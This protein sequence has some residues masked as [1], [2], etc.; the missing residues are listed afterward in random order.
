MPLTITAANVKLKGNTKPPVLVQ[1]GETVTQGQPLYP[2]ASDSNKFW[3]ADADTA[4][5]AAA[6]GIAMTPGVAGDYVLLAKEGCP[7]SLGAT[8]VVGQV[9]C[10]SATAGGIDAFS[11]VASGDYVTIIGV[12]SAADSITLIMEATGVAKA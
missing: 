3:K 1:V 12:A 8:L 7:I 2:K 4:A 11:D 9:Y 6:Q 5:E 10:V